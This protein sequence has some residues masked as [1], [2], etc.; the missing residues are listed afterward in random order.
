MTGEL[1][2][3]VD[4]KATLGEGPSW[5]ESSGVLYWVDILEK[6]VHIYDP[7]RGHDRSIEVPD[8]V[9]A[10]VPRAAGGL[11]MAMKDGFYSL[12]PSSGKT[13]PLALPGEVGETIRFNDGKCD[14]RGRFLAGTMSMRDACGQ[15]KL[16]SLH[17]DRSIETLVSPVTTSNGLTWSPDHRTFYYID[18]PTRQIVAYDYDLEAGTIANPRTVIRIPEG[19]GQPDG[20]TSDTEGMLWVAQWGGYCISRWNPRT[21]ERLEKIAVPVNRVTSCVFGGKNRSELYITT[22]RQGMDEEKEGKQPH[23]GGLFRVKTN[24]EGLPTF[25]FAG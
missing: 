22:A 7:L 13:D 24:A 9:G 14:P 6:K 19:E 23:A 3:L 15:G 1:E 16:Y 20:M 4:A 11:I 2:L 10:V 12:D 21:G 18:S 5:D 17:A 25:S 8:L